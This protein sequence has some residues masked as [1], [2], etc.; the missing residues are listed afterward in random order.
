M[1][2][3]VIVKK[4]PFSGRCVKIPKKLDI[5]KNKFYVFETLFKSQRWEDVKKLK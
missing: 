2:D 1:P 5:L 4:Y 3:N